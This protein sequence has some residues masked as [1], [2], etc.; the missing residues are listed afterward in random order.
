MKKM[1]TQLLKKTIKV[2]LTT[3]LVLISTPSQAYLTVG[4]STELPKQGQYRVGAEPQI[5][6]NN[7]GFNFSGF[8]DTAITSD[9]SIRA[10]LGIG[11]TSFEAAASYKWIPIPDYG[12]QPGIGGKVEASYANKSGGNWTALRFMPLISKNFD[13]QYGQVTPYGSIPLD[14]I[15]TP[16]TTQSAVQLV[17]GCEYRS[18]DYSKWM[19]SAELGLNLNNAF[20]YVSGNVTYY[21]DE[22]ESSV[23]TKH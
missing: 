8:A 21:L 13:T 10:H 4:E 11:D 1:K 6:F 16:S 22:T 20:S 5:V 2:S 17:G 15:G 14:L 3:L 7:G 23:K 18:P 12:N 19:F 9:S